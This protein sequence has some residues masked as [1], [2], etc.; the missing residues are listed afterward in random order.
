MVITPGKLDRL[1]ERMSSVYECRSKSPSWKNRRDLSYFI[2]L[3]RPR[4]AVV[5]FGACDR[6][7]ALYRKPV[8]LFPILSRLREFLPTRSEMR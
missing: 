7:A 4:G 1:V 3:L 8:R 6:P 5:A 2:R